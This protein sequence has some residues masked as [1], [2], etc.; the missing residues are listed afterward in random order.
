MEIH[1]F[2]LTKEVTVW[3]RDLLNRKA[4]LRFTPTSQPGLL[5]QYDPNH[6]PKL[7]TA[8]LLSARLRRTVL[9]FRKSTLDWYEHIGILRWL[10]LDSVVIQSS[11]WPP[12]FGRS[13]ELWEALRCL[14]KV[15]TTTEIPWCTV[16]QTIRYD[17]PPPRTGFVEIKP[18]TDPMLY[19]TIIC[20]YPGLGYEEFR[21]QI[22]HSLLE[23]ALEIYTPGWPPWLYYPSKT[24]S[25]LG[26]KHHTHV[27]WPRAYSQKVAL[28]RFIFHRLIDLLGTLS[29]IHSYAL[30]AGEVTSCSAG[31]LADVTVVKLSGQH[32]IPLSPSP[33]PNFDCRLSIPRNTLV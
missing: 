1:P 7:I 18:R 3:G 26:W 15:E 4:W 24:L 16:S 23:E 9:S 33:A 17:Y 27:S 21:C 28:H 13:N 11:A 14:C 32:L 30:F 5:W 22:T 8:D 20:D 19:V 2:R 25:Y 29:L 6:K 10:G 12:F 31:H